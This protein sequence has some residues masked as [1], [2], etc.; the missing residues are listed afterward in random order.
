[1]WGAWQASVA[2]EHKDIER[3]GRLHESSGDHH[4][5]R[6]LCRQRALPDQRN[7]GKVLEELRHASTHPDVNAVTRNSAVKPRSG[8]VYTASVHAFHSFPAQL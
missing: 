7:P 1:V 6:G 4:G 3:G 8:L 2:S 5:N